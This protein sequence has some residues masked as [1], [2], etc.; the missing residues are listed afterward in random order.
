MDSHMNSNATA[1]MVCSKSDAFRYLGSF[2]I[3]QRGLCL[4]MCCVILRIGLRG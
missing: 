3:I 1:S 2:V 4:R